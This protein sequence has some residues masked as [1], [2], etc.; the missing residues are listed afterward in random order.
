MSIKTLMEGKEV[1]GKMHIKKKRIW[2]SDE[3]GG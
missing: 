2:T 1:E 3:M